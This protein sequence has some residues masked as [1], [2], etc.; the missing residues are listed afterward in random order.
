MALD[1][2]YAERVVQLIAD[3]LTDA[4]ECAAAWAVGFVRFVMYQRAW[5][6]CRQR[7]ALDLLL[8]LGRR[9]GC[10]QCLK[11]SFNRRDRREH[12]LEGLLKLAGLARSTFYYQQKVQ[13]V[14]DK[15]AELKTRVCSFSTSTWADIAI[16]A[17]LLPLGELAT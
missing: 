13:P 15:N 7:G 10:L 3:V 17:S 11:L 8:F 16:A 6:F 9:R 5:K 2:K 14:V 12:P 4:L 1:G